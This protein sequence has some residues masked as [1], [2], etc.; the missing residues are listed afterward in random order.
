MD[1]EYKG[2]HFLRGSYVDPNDPDAKSYRLSPLPEKVQDS[3]TIWDNQMEYKQKIPISTIIRRKN[4][5]LPFSESESLKVDV[6]LQYGRYRNIILAGKETGSAAKETK[7]N[8]SGVKIV[9]LETGETQTS[10]HNSNRQFVIQQFVKLC[11]IFRVLLPNSA[12]LSYVKLFSARFSYKR[13]NN[14]CPS[15][16]RFISSCTL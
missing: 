1:S 15:S 7:P 2:D 16:I 4:I 6:T 11:M 13:R 8:F 10:F 12:P 9:S 14:S 3:V 5:E